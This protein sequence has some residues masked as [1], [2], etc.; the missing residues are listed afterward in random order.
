MK[1]TVSL[2][3]KWTNKVLIMKCMNVNMHCVDNLQHGIVLVG[4]ILQ[5]SAN[6]NL[7]HLLSNINAVL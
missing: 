2:K 3:D 4:C 1:S 6:V 5:E 7:L